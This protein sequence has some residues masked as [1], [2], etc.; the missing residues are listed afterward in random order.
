MKQVFIA[1]DPTEA[2]LIMGIL[3]AQGIQAEVRGAELFG[4]RGEVPMTEET[5]PS[6]WV[7][8]DSEAVK[9]RAVVMQFQKGGVAEEAHG[10]PWRCPGCGET[11]EPQF[12]QCWQCGQVRP[13]D[14]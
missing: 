3:E 6:V 4:L 12:T 13:G 2:H 8:E 7:R 5:S 1:K 9:A 11:I 14:Q 10:A